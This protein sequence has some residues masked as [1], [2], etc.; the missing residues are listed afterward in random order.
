MLRQ[1]ARSGCS[2]CA[3]R[4]A[5]FSA[6]CSERW[7]C[8]GR[9]RRAVDHGQRGPG[10]TAR[11]E[12]SG[13]PDPHV[14]GPCRCGGPEPRPAPPTRPPCRRENRR[15]TPVRAA[16]ASEPEPPAQVAGVEQGEADPGVGRGLRE[17]VRH[18]VR[19]GVRLAGRAV[20][21]VVELPDGG[22]AGQRHLGV[23]GAGQREVGVPG[24]AARRHRTSRR[25]RSRSRRHRSWVRP[26][27]ARW[28]AWLCAFA[29]PGRTTP[30][31]RSAPAASAVGTSG[32]TRVTRPPSAST[33]TSRRSP[34]GRGA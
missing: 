10:R 6:G 23:H 27:R 9:P 16:V 17:H 8:S 19:V 3:A 4:Q 24:P 20:V 15:C 13:G 12:C 32:R 14:A 28:N 22:D 31:N 21:Q 33:S 26:R 11:T 2:P 7:T 25:A 30:G 1:Q 5:S 18:L 34:S 29:K